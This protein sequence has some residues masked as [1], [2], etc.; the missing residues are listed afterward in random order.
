[1]PI[2]S[3]NP[4]TGVVEREFTELTHEQ[5]EEKLVRAQT[6][7]LAWRQV[8][9]AERAEKMHALAAYLRA[10][11]AEL[12][13]LMTLE[14]GKTVKAGPG[15]IEKCAKTCV[16]YADHAQEFLAPEPLKLS[17][18]E[19]YVQFDPLGVVLAV[20]PWNF[21]FWQ[22]I[23]F[24][25]PAIMAGNVGIL[26]HASNVPQC[27]EAI[28]AAF[29]AA[30]FPVGAF[31]NLL[32]SAS[33]V[34]AVI[35]DPRIKAVTLTGSE[36]AGSMVA[37]VAGEE[38][39]KTVLE[40]GGSDPFIV[41]ADADIEASAKAAALARLQGNVGQSCVA[42]KRFIVHAS[43]LHAF[44]EAMSAAFSLLKIG[45]PSDPATDVGP[46][47]SQKTLA[48]VDDQVKRSLTS[49]AVLVCG[50]H[51]V[52]EVGSFY[53]PT[54]LTN[55][56]TG[57]A[58]YDEEVFGPVA[59]LISFE[60]EAEAIRLAN[61][62]PYGLGSAIFTSDLERAK[63]VATQI[64]AGVVFINDYVKSDPGMP[65]GGVKKSGYGRELSHYGMREFVNVKTVA[66]T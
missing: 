34:E 16:Y 42:A 32:I 46:L 23:R 38:L 13:A 39:K 33:R 17:G 58:A 8:S 1:M 30:G 60:T 6:T 35:R 54:I 66:I 7:F 20:M 53:A 61:D 14:M 51:R 48:D 41:F 45:D 3:T 37:K 2:R 28:E 21:P 55:V 9:L 31:Q 62:T 36:Y 43:V 24:A 59:A 52:G 56:K 26:K 65:F 27:A 40:L 29:T 25:A 49:G 57:Q 10:Q 22:V 47:S 44:T 5:V 15:E 19:S 12:T 50:G 18:R 4:A 11:S 63:R 64:E